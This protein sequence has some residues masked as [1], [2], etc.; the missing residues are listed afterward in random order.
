MATGSWKGGGATV[1]DRAAAKAAKAKGGLGTFAGVFTPSILTILGLILF[2]R[3]GYVVGTGG[4]S[5]MLVVMGVAHVITV[6]TS[7]SLSAIA[8]NLRVKGG[9]DYYLIS[10]SLGVEFG[11]A[12]GIV[13]FLAQAISVAFYC[14]G[15]GEA[16]AVLLP[17]DLGFA[18][19]WLGPRTI[20]AGAMLFL[21]V[22]AW[23][24]ADWATRLQYVVMAALGLGLLSFFI[25]AW[26]SF[27]PEILSQNWGDP[28]GDTSTY[29]FLF[30][31]FFPAVTGFTQGV[32]MSGD[33]RDP[34]RSLPLGTFAAVAVSLVVY[35]SAAILFAGVAPGAELS[36]DNEAMG[37]ASLFPVLVLAG[38]V[39][40]TLSSA[41]AS[42][43]G[44][45]R[46]LQA[47]AADKVFPI[48]TPFAVGAGESSNP[49]RGVLMTLA[50]GLGV[51][52]LGGVNLIAPVVSMFFLISYGLLNYATALEARAQSPSFRP[53]FR[54]FHYRASLVGAV[55]CL[56]AMLMINPV[57]GAAAIALVFALYQ[58]VQRLVQPGRWS[59]GKRDFHFHEVRSNLFA[60]GR[61]PVHPRNWRPQLLVFSQRPERRDALVRFAGWIEG[62]AGITTVARI[63]EGNGPELVEQCR[64]EQELLGQELEEKKVA[65]FPLVVAVPDFASGHQT[66]IQSYGV[67]P[68]KAN[69]I[70]VNWLGAGA[71]PEVAP[72]EWTE[73]L[74]VR[75]LRAAKRL[76][77]NAIVLNAKAEQIAAVDASPAEERRIDVWWSDDPT[78]HLMVL[79]AYMMTR[80][81]DW[82][83]AT[84]RLLVRVERGT[85]TKIRARLQ[86]QLE[87]VRIDAL[88]ETMENVNHDKLVVRSRDAALVMLPL[89]TKSMRTVDPFGKPVE[90]LLAELPAVALVSATEDIS[91]D[92]EDEDE[93]P[94]DVVESGSEKEAGK[95]GGGKKDGGDE[96]TPAA[97]GSEAD[98]EASAEDAP[99][100]EDA[101]DPNPPPA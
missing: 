72:D 28:G 79:L 73:R 70:V 47:L 35:V 87:D 23:L 78:G 86:E 74:Y 20:A 32:S 41:L 57:A 22:F 71:E 7:M 91:L 31:L 10:R 26:S 76:G 4:L 19:G 55:A 67:G 14:L 11:G 42:F 99:G 92:V 68:M 54:F 25:G 6:L 16:L 84:I 62:G 30:A 53:R 51:V 49:R 83:G 12:L 21:S 66:L 3:L 75:H 1:V 43:M 13:L 85:G 52:A 65:A 81:D 77:V 17:T 50:I 39:A 82:T 27:S 5:K 60:M 36:A 15:F 100:A 34:G 44:A 64:R 46:I 89:R 61:V 101:G 80:S 88:I 18:D 56:G 37:R 98:A 48:L 24:G 94:A 2:S 9:G 69:C 58:Y 38:I 40:A 33:L 96:P 45:P 90:K 97:E 29:P 63:L 95:K 8:T 93:E 59:T